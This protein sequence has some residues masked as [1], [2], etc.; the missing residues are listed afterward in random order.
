MPYSLISQVENEYDKL[1]EADE[2]FPVFHS[3]WASP[4]V[5]VPKA[6]GSIRICGDYKALNE[7]N[8]DDWY[9]L[10]SVKDMFAMLS[11]DGCQRDTRQKNNLFVA[12]GSQKFI[13]YAS[14]A[15]SMAERNYA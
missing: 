15:L 9:K 2:L 12:L 10:P 7:R 4:V 6:D 8:D 1:V 3:S 11:Q 13:E 5:H 14:R